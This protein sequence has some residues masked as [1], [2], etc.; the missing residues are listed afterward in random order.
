M[1]EFSARLDRLEQ[2]ADET[3]NQRQRL[4]QL[5]EETRDITSRL[6][7]LTQMEQPLH[8]L[9]QC[10]NAMQ[11]QAAALGQMSNTL[12][13]VITLYRRAEQSN[14]QTDTSSL[15]PFLQAELVD[16]LGP[17]TPVHVPENTWHGILYDLQRLLD[18]IAEPVFLERS[19]LLWNLCDASTPPLPVTVTGVL[20]RC[21]WW[22]GNTA[23][24]GMCN[25]GTVPMLDSS[26]IHQL[27]I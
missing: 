27:Q 17:R 3:W 8:L 16:I 14:L 11:E 22:Y 26:I 2:I 6:K 9:V 20:E 4:D 15:S 5:A 21:G 24:R 23:A 10:R 25:T 1:P 13:T 12:D 18:R 19:A 7:T